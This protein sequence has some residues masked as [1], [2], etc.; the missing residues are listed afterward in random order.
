M[1]CRSDHKFW[2]AAGSGAIRYDTILYD[3]LFGFRISNLRSSPRIARYSTSIQRNSHQRQ[4][5]PIQPESNM[6]THNVQPS[7]A[8]SASG[9]Q[10]GLDVS[11]GAGAAVPP[12]PPALL[13]LIPQ[14]KAARGHDDG[15]IARHIISLAWDGTLN[16]LT[17]D[18]DVP[19]AD[20]IQRSTA[21][22]EEAVPG[23]MSEVR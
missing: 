1:V 7:T 9:R 17:S 5:L 22:L 10:A 23:F 14:I 21:I 13:R 4:R 19:L 12:V 15:E 8:A 2:R 6:S 18:R 11:T 3:I 16:I 20:A